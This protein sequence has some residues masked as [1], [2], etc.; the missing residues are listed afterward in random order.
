MRSIAV[1]FLFFTLAG[2]GI[3]LSRSSHRDTAHAAKAQVSSAGPIPIC[4]SSPCPTIPA[5]P[6]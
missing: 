1:A 6:R 2:T 3:S 5:P 4:P